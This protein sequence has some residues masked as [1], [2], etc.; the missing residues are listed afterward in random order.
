MRYRWRAGPHRGLG[1]EASI[2]RTSQTTTKIQVGNARTGP[3]AKFTAIR[4]DFEQ[5]V[6][7]ASWRGE[8]QRV[9]IV[10]NGEDNVEVSWC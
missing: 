2:Q 3:G 10:W 9:Q 8:C 4:T 5:Q 7:E 1:A 6:E